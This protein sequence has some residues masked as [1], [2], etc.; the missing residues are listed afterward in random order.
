MYISCVPTPPHPHSMVMVHPGDAR[1]PPLCDVEF[2]WINCFL[3]DVSGVCSVHA[4]ERSYTQPCMQSRDIHK[5]MH[6][7]I[8]ASRFGLD[9]CACISMHVCIS[10]HV[11]VHVF[12][13]HAYTCIYAYIYIL[14]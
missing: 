2:S 13:I 9:A 10:V 1:T 14:V 3:V 6:V 8:D 11:C 4:S 5:C 7:C 12:N